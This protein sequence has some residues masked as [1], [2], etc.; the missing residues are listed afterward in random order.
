MFL[1][2]DPSDET[3]FALFTDNRDDATNFEIKYTT[4]LTV[5]SPQFQG[6]ITAIQIDASDYTDLLFIVGSQGMFPVASICAIVGGLYSARLL[7]MQYS[8]PALDHRHST[9][10]LDYQT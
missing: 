8:T 7:S 3:Q 6:E 5:T 10:Q 2:V 4:Q 9:S 1:Q